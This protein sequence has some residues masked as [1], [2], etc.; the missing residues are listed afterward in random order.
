MN[1]ELSDIERA[2]LKKVLDSYLSE[3]RLEIRATKGE[4]LSMH[5]EEELVKKLVQKMS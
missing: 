2:L 5:A 3:L 1:L 4:K